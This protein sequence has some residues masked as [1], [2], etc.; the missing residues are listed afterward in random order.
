M[1]DF[2]TTSDR[3]VVH[4]FLVDV[5]INKDLLK[6]TTME[7]LRLRIQYGPQHMDGVVLVN[8]R[9]CGMPLESHDRT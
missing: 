9:Y 4:Q 5:L 8:T 2:N 3:N 7:D 1:P 6:G